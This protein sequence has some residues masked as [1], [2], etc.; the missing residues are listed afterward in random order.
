MF[1]AKTV[2]SHAGPPRGQPILGYLIWGRQNHYLPGKAPLQAPL[3]RQMGPREAVDYVHHWRGG[4]FRA[5]N[6]FFFKAEDQKLVP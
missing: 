4:S 6:T 2:S 1:S 3:P 5:I